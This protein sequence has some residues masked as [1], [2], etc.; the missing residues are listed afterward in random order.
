MSTIDDPIIAE[1]RRQFIERQKTYMQAWQKAIDG[2]TTHFPEAIFKEEF[3][4]LFCGED[5]VGVL[6]KL[7]LWKTIAQGWSRGVWLIDGHKRP[8]L[9]VPPLVAFQILEPISERNAVPMAFHVQMAGTLSERG[10]GAG[11][12]YMRQNMLD[13]IKHMAR[14]IKSKRPLIEQQ[15]RKVFEFYG[16]SPSLD[17]PEA[18][19]APAIE[20]QTAP[21]PEPDDE[22]DY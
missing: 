5:H 4:P 18:T 16:K 22:Y 12:A 21:N 11:D 2:G 14:N 6:E 1:N 8:V 20:N 3:L 9:F 13:Q 19:Q 10:I 17:R 15:W 7:E